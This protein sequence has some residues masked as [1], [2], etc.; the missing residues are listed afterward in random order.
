MKHPKNVQE[1]LALGKVERYTAGE[2][3]NALKPDGKEDSEV[4]VNIW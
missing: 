1:N 4:T 2:F 3:W